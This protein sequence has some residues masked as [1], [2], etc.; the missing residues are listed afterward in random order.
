MWRLLPHGIFELPA[1]I[2][3]IGIGLKLG[4]E[5]WKKDSWNVLKRN[6]IES[7][8]FFIFIIMPLLVIAA[9]IEGL[10]ISLV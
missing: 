4:V 5:I 7:L 2:L 9:I 3:S 6:I 8:R 10:L 1:I